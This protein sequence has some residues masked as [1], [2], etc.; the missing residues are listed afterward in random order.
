MKINLILLLLFIS[1]IYS[2][3]QRPI[4]PEFDKLWEDFRFE[5]F[6]E[7]EHLNN[8]QNYKGSPYLDFDENSCALILLNAQKIEGLTIR[9]NIYHDQME[10][11]REGIYYVIPR[12]KELA[13]FQLA[14][15]HFKYLIFSD[16][17]QITTGN[18]EV[19]TEG[20]CTLYK[21]FHVFLADAQPAKPYQEPKPAEFK[22]K[23]S[24]YFIGVE[25]KTPI[26][27]KNG[28]DLLG[29]LPDHHDEMALFIKTNKLTFRQEDDFIKAI[30]YY[31][32]L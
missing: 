28:K 12:Q 9:Y 16:K 6:A 30:A 7:G 18:L 27:I 10:L 22:S 32:S 29:L 31:N 14:G 11:K 8:N 1:T 25:E 24:T 26:K 23:A 4:S 2:L 15:H 3:S 20:K 21:Q 13:A 19:L 17:N 5:K